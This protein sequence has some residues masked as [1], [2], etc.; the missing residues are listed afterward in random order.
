MLLQSINRQIKQ[1]KTIIIKYERIK[2]AILDNNVNIC[3]YH[4]IWDN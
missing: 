4:F 1:V 3:N 2:G